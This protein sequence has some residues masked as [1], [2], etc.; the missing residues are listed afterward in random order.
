MGRGRRADRSA[1]PAAPG[2]LRQLRAAVMKDPAVTAARIE[3]RMAE[4]RLLA[5]TT[6]LRLTWK[7][8]R[9]TLRRSLREARRTARID[10]GI[11]SLPLY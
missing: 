3:V 7:E 8:M 10:D 1:E 9:Q 11:G 6:T 4:L 5:A 2:S